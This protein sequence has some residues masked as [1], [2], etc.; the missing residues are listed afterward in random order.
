T[1]PKNVDNKLLEELHVKRISEGPSPPM[2]ETKP[3]SPP[4]PGAKEKNSHP[5]SPIIPLKPLSSKD[6]VE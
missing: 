1:T 5:F 3:D 6:V 2:Q 4:S